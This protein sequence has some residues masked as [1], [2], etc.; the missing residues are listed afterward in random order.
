M[1]ASGLCKP[2]RRRKRHVERSEK[3]RKSQRLDETT[4]WTPIL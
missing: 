3:R 4:E 2:N 1:H